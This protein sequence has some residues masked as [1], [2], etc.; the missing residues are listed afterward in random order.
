M[1][2]RL[3]IACIALCG[4]AITTSCNKEKQNELFGIPEGALLLT[5]EN[6]SNQAK[7]E[8]EG[9]AV[10]WVDGDEVNVNGND[11]SVV[12]NGDVAYINGSGISGSVF[13][14]YPSNLVASD[15]QTT[16]PTVSFPSTY[17]SALG[18][19]SQII[20]LPM[21]AYSPSV[22]NTILFKHLSAT[23]NVMMLN[24]MS[25]TLY[26]SNVIV[27]SESQR[28]NG[29]ITLDLT[30]D[31]LGLAPSY[32]STSETERT[33]TVS[34]G[35]SP[36]AVGVG[37]DNITS[38]QV[39]ILP[40]YNDK[41]TVEVE[42]TDGNGYSYLYSYTPDSPVTIGRKELLDAR[43]K[44]STANGDHMRQVTDLS[45]LTQDYTA[46]DGETLAGELDPLYKLN[47]ANNA[48]VTLRNMT[49]NVPSGTTDNI[50][51]NPGINCLGNATLILEG[52]NLV[53]G[54]SHSSRGVNGESS[55]GI[56]IPS[57]YTLTIKG[58]G[59]LTATGGKASAGIGAG[60]QQSGDAGNIIIESGTI[61]AN[62]I[63][64]TP[65]SS[66]AGIGGCMGRNVGD[67]TING[68]TV[69]AT[70][71][72]H[73]CGIGS[74]GANNSANN[75]SS[76][77]S[78][79]GNITING[80]I[81]TASAGTN[82][83]GIGTGYCNMSNYQLQCGSI[84]INGGTVTATGHYNS[85]NGNGVGIGAGTCSGSGTNST[86][87]GPITVNG[88]T[89]TA[90]GGCTSAAIGAGHAWS[91][92]GSSNSC[93]CESISINGG[94]VT[95]TIAPYGNINQG[96]A[97]GSGLTTIGQAPGYPSS[98]VGTI[99]INNGASRVVMT[100][101]TN[102][103]KANNWSIGNNATGTDAITDPSGSYMPFA[104]STSGNTWTLSNE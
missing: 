6:T 95:A 34:F 47:I 32:T 53:Q 85:S 44:L 92:G 33:V 54:G 45:T 103:I 48:T 27:R 24:N 88:G 28:I 82:G 58:N 84:T 87:C 55:A 96:S 51:K 29:I 11:Y 18:T 60:N 12:V 76:S 56:Y 4:I 7:T 52:I 14:Y 17:A 70:G 38:I 9:L 35:N 86:S 89:V 93:R 68:G 31:N 59:Q 74:G 102:Y 97:I 3:T 101:G 66:S 63:G 100:K 81:V 80:G 1:T 42:C 83:N 19:N 75:L 26:V 79:C 5:T 67:I 69:I 43:V 46:Q 41:L 15:G 25:T 49:H 77:S 61:I 21:A 99:T 16:E 71:A 104:T 94:F 73:G 57:P 98:S 90:T 50:T 78:S 91:G 65:S 39:P 13:A 8:V 37:T 20:P 36:V 23:V 72:A 40:I 2:K 30:D 62:V 64:I 10:R 22:G